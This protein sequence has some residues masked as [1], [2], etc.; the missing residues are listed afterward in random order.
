M[1]PDIYQY[2]KSEEAQFESNEIQVGDNWFWNMRNHIQMIFHLKNGIFYTGDNNWLRAFKNIMEPILNLAYWTEDLEVKDVEFYTENKNNRVVSF[3]SKKYHEEVYTKEHDLDAM[4]DDITENDLDYGGVIAQKGVDQPEVLQLNQIAFCDQTDILGGPIGF[5]LHFSPEKLRSMSTYGWGNENNGATISLEDLCTLATFDKDT[6]G[7]QN[8]NKNQVPGKAIEIYIIRGNLPDHY[9]TDSNDM[10]Y[11]CNQLQVIAYYTDKESRKIGKTLYR[12]KEKEGNLKFFTSK[13]IH[14][15]GLGRGEGEILL[16]PQIWTNFSTIY[17][18]GLVE[19]A[20]KVGLYTDDSTYTTKNKI[21]D[22]ENLE[23]TTIE[24]GKKIY[25]IPTAAPA[26]LQLIEGSINDWYSHAQLAGAAFDPIMGKEPPSGTT[27]RGQER[28]VAQGKGLHDRRRGQRAKF[29]E[30]I[31]RDWILPD[32][33]KGMK[34]KKFLATLTTE[35]MAWVA[36]QVAINETNKQVIDLIIQGKAPTKEEQDALFKQIKSDFIKKGNKHLIELLDNEFDDIELK[37]GI[38]IANK[39]KNLADLSDKVL[40]II[41]FA[42]QDPQR[43]NQ[44]LLIPGMAQSFSDI[45]EYSG[46]S[47]VS[48]SELLNTQTQQIESPQQFVPVQSPIQPQ[49]NQAPNQILQ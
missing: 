49:L 45:L 12:K 14:G 5:K 33:K 21:Q 18:M 44:T 26:N 15:R 34:S 29:I 38:N 3:F 22:M 48:F 46:L 36:D 41:Q 47:P 40:S 6:P 8:G 19:A 17:K 27:F 31:Y 37:V 9:L 43:F 2:V 35:E 23:I 42:F 4:I 1:N 30:E 25:Q 39:Q 28:N 10:E 11:F 16:H 13:K 20:G 7:T 32:M 24:D